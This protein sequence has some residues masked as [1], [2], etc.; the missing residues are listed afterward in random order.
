MGC[1]YNIPFMLV[2]PRAD[3]VNRSDSSILLFVPS[4]QSVLSTLS[5]SKNSNL[6]TCVEIRKGELRG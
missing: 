2:P 6:Q 1:G 3:D 5:F 4:T